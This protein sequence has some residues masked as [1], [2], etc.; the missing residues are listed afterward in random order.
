MITQ[1]SPSDLSLLTRAVHQFRGEGSGEQF[2]RTPGAMAFV[3]ADGPTVQVQGWCWGHHLV[4]PDGAPMAH[5]HELTVAEDFRRRG[6]GR[7]LLKAFVTA[8][9]AAGATRMFLTTGADNVPARALYDSV[10]GGLAEQGRT[11]NYWFVL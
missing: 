3:A 9:R 1:I 6:V 11:V 10:G 8:A 5:L 4:R 7:E 2:A